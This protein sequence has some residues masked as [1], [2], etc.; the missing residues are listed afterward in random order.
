[1]VGGT[2]SSESFF[3]IVDLL[4]QGEQPWN[5]V[6]KTPQT[7]N[8]WYKDTNTVVDQRRSTWEVCEDKVKT[9]NGGVGAVVA[10]VVG[11]RPFVC[12]GSNASTSCYRY[13]T[14]VWTK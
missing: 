5:G 2:N 14:S 11:D 13:A 6:S 10:A 3:E 8:Y 4:A 7:C 1:V 9:F 12:G